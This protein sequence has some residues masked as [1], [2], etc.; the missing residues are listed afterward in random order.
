MDVNDHFAPTIYITC[1]P[2]CG[3]ALDDPVL[4]YAAF[5][6]GFPAAGQLTRIYRRMSYSQPCKTTLQG[7]APK[8]KNPP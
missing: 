4:S 8:R 5:I 2:E 3:L 7:L 1:D 6:K